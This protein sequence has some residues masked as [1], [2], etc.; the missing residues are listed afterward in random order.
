[1]LRSP[2][3]HASLFLSALLW[4]LWKPGTWWDTTLTVIPSLLSFSIA[5][6]A[7]YL[8]VGDA[9][10]R[11]LIA[12]KDDDQ[13]D[14]EPSD[15]VKFTATFMHFIVVQIVALLVALV[16]K[17]A[18]LVRAPDVLSLPLIIEALRL[19]FWFVGFAVFLYA[20]FTALAT[21]VELFRLA[22]I[23]DKF[24]RLSPPPDDPQS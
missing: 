15:F 4:P 3:L 16:A 21:T 10:F 14:E 7:M 8:A 20:L 19:P 2:Y 23:L 9:Q 24:L 17:A 1:M 12:H 13:A 5:G 22:G 6:F 11:A 18:F